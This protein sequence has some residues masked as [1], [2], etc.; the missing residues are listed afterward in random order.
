[1][2]IFLNQLGIEVEDYVDK[3]L[4]VME[5]F[6]EYDPEGFEKSFIKRQYEIL[7]RIKEAGYKPKA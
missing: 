6:K 5:K 7:Q 4:D 2:E 1:M 3:Q